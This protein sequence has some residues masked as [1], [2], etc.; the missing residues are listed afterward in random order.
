M[1]SG[2]HT[3]EFTGRATVDL[4]D[5]VRW[6]AE[7]HGVARFHEEPTGPV[8]RVGIPSAG[9]DP[10]VVLLP[11]DEPTAGLLAAVTAAR[12]EIDAR[13]RRARLAIA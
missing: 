10:V 4:T 13:T 3:T 8:I 5:A 12:A 1:P 9:Q 7:S 11:C 2:E 6:L